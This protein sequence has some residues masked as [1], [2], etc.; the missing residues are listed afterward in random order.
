MI[1][2]V[3]DMEIDKFNHPDRPLPKGLLKPSVVMICAG[4][5][6]MPGLYIAVMVDITLLFLVAGSL[7]LDYAYEKWLKDRGLLGN[8]AA[9]LLVGGAF[10]AG[11]IVTDNVLV[12][13][14]IGYLA[15]LANTGREIVKDMEDIKGDIGRRT[16]VKA[17]GKKKASMLAGM[18]LI[19]PIVF[20]FFIAFPMG[21]G[22]ILYPVFIALSG[23]CFITAT[24]I[25]MRN[26]K[27]SQ[28]AA[29]LGMVCAL[30]GFLF[31]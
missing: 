1:N 15:F 3:F 14:M 17:Y 7:I 21:Y 28:N 30:A 5:L 8:L 19:S 12:G 13:A 20:G 22:N 2:D 6:V 29:K 27:L 10:L 31:G 25:A 18:F 4:F 9:G 24:V 26:P 11:G 23:V 16:A